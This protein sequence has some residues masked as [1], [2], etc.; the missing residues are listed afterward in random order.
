MSVYSL[1]GGARA[2]PI[3]EAD[4]K[5]LVR[6][7]QARYKNEIE[8]YTRLR[9]S[10]AKVFTDYARYMADYP[11]SVARAAAI[12]QQQAAKAGKPKRSRKRSAPHPPPPPM[13]LRLKIPQLPA[14]PQRKRIAPTLVAPL[15]SRDDDIVYPSAPSSA[16]K[17]K[18][19]FSLDP[20]IE[21]VFKQRY[22]AKEW[23]EMTPEERR[24]LVDLA[25][26][27]ASGLKANRRH[28]KRVLGIRKKN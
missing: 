3:D 1:V 27:M 2:L 6:E 8:A 14:A 12:R 26:D 28:L 23:Q 25:D 5:R 7:L 9:R 4:R 10:N 13:I 20:S 16:P 19:D 24:T 17:R 15:P 22:G 21:R 11:Y 18:Q